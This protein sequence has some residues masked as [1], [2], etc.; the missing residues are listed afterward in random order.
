MHTNELGCVFTQHAIRN[1][2]YATR[3]TFYALRAMAAYVY[4]LRCADG[5]YYTGWTTDLARRLAAHQAGRA[6]RYTRSRRPVT[7]AYW[8]ECADARAARRREYRLRHQSHATKRAL[9]RADSP[10][11]S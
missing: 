6:A 9:A 1:T 2:F 10:C 5:S 7:L 11:G 8:E 4:L 3:F